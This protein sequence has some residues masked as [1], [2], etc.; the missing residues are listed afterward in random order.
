[1][2]VTPVAPIAAH[3]SSAMMAAPY[4]WKHFMRIAAL[5]I[6]ACVLLAACGG[7]DDYESREVPFIR[8]YAQWAFVD[9][10]QT[11]VI[12]NPEEWHALWINYA[13]EARSN[14]PYARFPGVDF[15]RHMVLGLTHGVASNLCYSLGI[16]SVTEHEH[17][18]EVEY[19]ESTPDPNATCPQAMADLTDF[20]VVVRSDKPVTFRRGSS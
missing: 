19:L 5:A 3:G 17:E 13:L 4:F 18:L 8:V 2:D 16:R 20:V 11:Y 15:S 7:S 10:R 1:V 6:S 12:R 9:M 14:Q